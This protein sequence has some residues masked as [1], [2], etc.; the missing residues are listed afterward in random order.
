MLIKND[1]YGIFFSNLDLVKELFESIDIRNSMIRQL[2]DD[3]RILLEMDLSNL[4][5]EGFNLRFTNLKNKLEILSTF[6]KMN[7]DI[8]FNYDDKW[9]FFDSILKYK[10]RIPIEDLLTNKF[11]GQLPFDINQFN[12]ITEIDFSDNEIDYINTIR[13]NFNQDTLIL[14]LGQPSKL[15]IETKDEKVDLNKN[16]N[17]PINND[18][19]IGK[20]INIYIEPIIL[21]G[22]KVKLTI[23]ESKAAS[24]KYLLKFSSEN[25]GTP[26]DM[27]EQV[28]LI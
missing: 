22:N 11:I 14:E 17:F 27:Y 21:S 2:S 7:S 20:K 8:D 1:K 3:K 5:E 6:N 24:T 26:I 16:F 13:K 4:F 12:Y 10:A 23:F 25:Y 9:Y 18:N 28:E 15:K 19:L